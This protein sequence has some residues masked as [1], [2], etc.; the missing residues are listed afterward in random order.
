MKKNRKYTYYPKFN[1]KKIYQEKKPYILSI[2]F[3]KAFDSI[4]RFK[5]QQVSLEYKIHPRIINNI[6]DTYINDKTSLFLL[7]IK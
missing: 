5:L 7:M 1:T 2:D 4:D 6:A 3:T